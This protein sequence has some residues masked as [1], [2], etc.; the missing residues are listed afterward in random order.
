MLDSRNLSPVILLCAVQCGMDHCAQREVFQLIL[1]DKEELEAVA[2]VLNDV[3]QMPLDSCEV[4]VSGR[5][6]VAVIG[7]CQSVGKKCITIK[8]VKKAE[9]VPIPP[10]YYNLIAL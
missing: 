1:V 4:R 6:R 9:S 3:L 5:E 10:S 2:L 7:T 8:D